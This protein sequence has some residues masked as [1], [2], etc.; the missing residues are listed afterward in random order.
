MALTKVSYSVISGAVANIL[1]YG[2]DPT[3]VADSTAAITAAIA[4]S[5]CVYIP[6]G[7]FKITSLAINKTNFYMYGC[8]DSS[9]LQ[10]TVAANIALTI[11]NT[12]N[13][14]N[15]TLRQFKIQGNSTN[16]GGIQLGT[17]TNLVAFVLLDE[18]TVRDIDNFAT[19][20]YGIRL[21]SV[22][23]LEVRNCRLLYNYYNVYQTFEG[24]V[25][26]TLFC[27]KKSYIGRGG[28]GF[29]F[30]GMISDITIRDCV[31]EENRAEG[32]L[33]DFY[34]D[35][36][37]IS[38][39]YFEQNCLGGTGNGHIYVTGNNATPYQYS[40]VNIERCSFHLMT[41]GT[42]PNVKLDK[43]KAL[44]IGNYE[45]I[46]IN[47]GV[48]TTAF[49]SASFIQNKSQGADNPIAIYK[50]LL[51]NISAMDTDEN[52]TQFVLSKQMAYI[53]LT[54]A[55]AANN[56]TYVSTSDGKLYFR[57]SSGA[58]FALY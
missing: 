24:F 16:L 47:A 39:C 41:A 11:G 43:T 5:N 44:F 9:V 32:I 22:Q 58:D 10:T 12:T 46:A 37:T 13:T 55:L 42:F 6:Q 48:V 38:D 40:H 33:S 15:V 26:S 1:D 4:D 45:L 25:T 7:T 34:Q 53:P 29:Y 28:I 56:T 31:I 20:S 50:A 3:G 23:E 52:G 54:P 8:G 49:T 51:G 36:I 19:L 14:E 2:A 21:R 35:D 18:L 30:N 27:G 57:N 17:A